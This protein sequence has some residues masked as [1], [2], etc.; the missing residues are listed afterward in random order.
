MKYR[1]EACGDMFELAVTAISGGD[2]KKIAKDGQESRLYERLIEANNNE[3]V[4]YG[5]YQLEGRPRF[6]VYVNDSPI[7]LE[8]RF[9]T[10]FKRIYHPIDGSTGAMKGKE[11]FYFVTER[12]HKKGSCTLDI[13]DGFDPKKLAMHYERYGLF[14]GTIC[15]VINLAY[16]DLDFDFVS[17]DT[18][19]ETSY[20]ISTKGKIFTIELQPV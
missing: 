20:I 15:S 10:A 13:D 18:N 6:E 1:L 9:S 16:A 14:N 11:Q 3:S 17:S 12:G 4:L 2:F 8:N 5:F 19:Y 7:N